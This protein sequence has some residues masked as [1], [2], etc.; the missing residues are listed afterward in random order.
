MEQHDE[1]DVLEELVLDSMGNLGI[2]LDQL[3]L[4]IWQRLLVQLGQHDCIG[5]IVELVDSSE[6]LVDD[7]NGYMLEL[8]D[9]SDWLVDPNDCML[10][11]ELGHEE[12]HYHRLGIQGTLIKKLVY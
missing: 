12:Q 2:C 5:S 7:P 1:R 10:E 9:S 8:V 11:H 6:Q 4:D 3:Q